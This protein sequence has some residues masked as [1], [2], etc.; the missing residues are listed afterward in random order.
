[1]TGGASMPA[2]K[3]LAWRCRRGMRELDTLLS[4]YLER[5][6]PTASAAERQAF[7]GLLDRPDPEIWSL[8]LGNA[9]SADPELRHV[10]E[11]IAGS[12]ART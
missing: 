4:T 2:G 9:A 5:C 7:E 1:M 3:K 6:Y 10:I 8:L 12:G 11:R